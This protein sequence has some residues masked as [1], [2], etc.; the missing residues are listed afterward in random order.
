MEL[1]VRDLKTNTIYSSNMSDNNKHCILEIHFC[2]SYT[3]VVV[4]DEVEEA[5]GK[6][7]PSHD[8]VL[9]PIGSEVNW[10]DLIATQEDNQGEWA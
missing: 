6:V 10:V 7:Y 1:K 3:Q 8:I 4:Q 2:T 9:P 5:G